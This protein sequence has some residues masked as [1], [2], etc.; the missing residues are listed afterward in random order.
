MKPRTVWR[1]PTALAA[2]TSFGLLSALL[3]EGGVW[4]GLSWAALSMP[5]LVIGWCS[6]KAIVSRAGIP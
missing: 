5:L 1:W 3:G 2:V 4:W 6:A